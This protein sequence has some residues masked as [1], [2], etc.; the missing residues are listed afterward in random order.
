MTQLLPPIAQTIAASSL[1]GN[2]TAS[3]CSS[4]RIMA[5]HESSDH[6]SLPQLSAA[7][8]ALPATGP[9]TI[10]A[11]SLSQGRCRQPSSRRRSSQARRCCNLQFPVQLLSSM[12]PLPQPSPAS[13][14][15]IAAK[16]SPLPPPLP[17][18]DDAPFQVLTMISL[19]HGFSP[20]AGN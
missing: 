1:P 2:P 12:S 17:C 16:P 18:L 4:R 20:F 5:F 9:V 8:P 11:V 19:S 3:L 10:D 6:G 13:A 7:S 14:P 15:Y